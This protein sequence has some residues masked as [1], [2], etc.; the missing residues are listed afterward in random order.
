MHEDSDVHVTHPLGWERSGLLVVC[1]ISTGCPLQRL[2]M[3]LHEGP[4]LHSRLGT[5]S[6][7]QGVVTDWCSGSNGLTLVVQQYERGV[8]YRRV[9]NKETHK[10]D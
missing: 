6:C 7:G 5:L 2:R 8:N 3:P 1:V 10:Y 4:P 9:H